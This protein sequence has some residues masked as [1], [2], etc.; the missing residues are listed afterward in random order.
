MITTESGCAA[1]MNSTLWQKRQRTDD[2]E[3]E[4][5]TKE[6]EEK[7]QKGQSRS[8]GKGKSSGPRA[9]PV[10]YNCGEPGH[11]A[12]ECTQPKGTGKGKNWIPASQWIQY[13]PG[14]IPRKWNNWRPGYR[15][16]KGKGEQ[17]KGKGGMGMVADGYNLSFPQLGVISKSGHG[18]DWSWGEVQTGSM[19]LGCLSCKNHDRSKQSGFEKPKKKK[20]VRFVKFECQQELHQAMTYNKFATLKDNQ[21][22]NDVKRIAFE[23]DEEDDE[24][25]IKIKKGRTESEQGSAKKSVAMLTKTKDVYMGACGENVE[26]DAS[27]WRRISIAVDSGA[28]DNVISPDDVPEQTVFESVGSKKGENF[29]SAT[30]EPIPNLGDIKM[31]MVMCEGTTRGMLMRAAPVSKPLASVKRKSQAGHTVVFDEQGSFIVNKSTGEINWLR[32]RW[33]LNAGCVDSSTRIPW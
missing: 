23:E 18:E 12:R 9:K 6:S 16:G 25:P 32:R 19:M 8:K 26:K 10:C 27:T 1:S 3:D 20:T 14:S 33:Q 13:N 21:E 28:C 7:Q 5:D 17:G 4:M 31:P 30:G 29:F 11:F 24:R 22:E 15:K 2:G